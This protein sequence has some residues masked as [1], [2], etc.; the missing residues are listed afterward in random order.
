MLRKALHHFSNLRYFF[1][2]N[3]Q[4][5]NAENL[6]SPLNHDSNSNSNITIEM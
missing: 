6:V 5:L 2:N 3:V 4:L 1:E